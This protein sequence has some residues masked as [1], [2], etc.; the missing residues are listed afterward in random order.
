M[1]S[2]ASALKQ[3][4]DF[5]HP[6]ADYLYVA[7]VPQEKWEEFYS[8]FGYYCYS[9]TTPE[10]TK[11][12]AFL[13]I[14][15][16]GKVPIF[17]DTKQAERNAAEWDRLCKEGKE[18]LFMEPKQSEWWDRLCKEEAGKHDAQTQTEDK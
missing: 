14:H 11:A 4:I 17:V 8:Q 6:W 18:S 16:N 2:N 10:S 12:A 7:K 1:S 9:V 13:W 5:S 15:K 3:K